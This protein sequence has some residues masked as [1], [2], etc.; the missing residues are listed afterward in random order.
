M[1]P[2]AQ[3]DAIVVSIDAGQLTLSSPDGRC[4]GCR[5]GCGGRCNVFRPGDGG[6]ITVPRPAAM[7]LGLVPGDRVRLS[8]D[9]EAL[10]RAAFAGYGLACIG[11]VAGAALG[12]GLALGLGVPRDPATLMGLAAGTVWALARSKRHVF[13]PRLEKLPPDPYPDP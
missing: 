11:L 8:V 6:V 4:E 5:I 9:E 3:R 13:A 12:Y 7:Q 1:V 10:R 2:V